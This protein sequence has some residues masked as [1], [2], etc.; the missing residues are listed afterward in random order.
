MVGHSWGGHLLLHVAVAH[1]ERLHG[2]LAVDPLGGVGDGAGEAFEAEMYARTPE[3]VRAS[4]DDEAW[5]AWARGTTGISTATPTASSRNP[6][7]MSP[8]YWWL[9]SIIHWMR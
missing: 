5:T 2:G 7:R 6:A 8:M 4:L 9:I 3:A 1:P